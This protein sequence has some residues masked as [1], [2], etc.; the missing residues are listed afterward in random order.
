LHADRAIPWFQRAIEHETV[1]VLRAVATRNLAGAWLWSHRLDQAEETARTA[2]RLAE[3]AAGKNARETLVPELIIASVLFERG[4]YDRVEP[5]FRRLQFQA[6]HYWG[7]DSYEAGVIAGNLGLLYLNQQRYSQARPM[8]EKSAKVLLRH[9]GLAATFDIL[10]CR[11]LIA[12][13]LASENR[14]READA[15]LGPVLRDAEIALG[16]DSIELA[17]LLMRAGLAKL[18][19][20]QADEGRRMFE[21]AIGIFEAQNGVGSPEAVAASKRYLGALLEAK[22]SR[23]A[24]QVAARLKSAGRFIPLNYTPDPERIRPECASQRN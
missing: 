18:R 14:V 6:E 3:A 22:D 15:L 8:L 7:A 17:N 11:V 4:E 19:M 23:H 13:T 16:A 20:K 10:H 24:R 21:H 9:S 1:P 12:L 5:V 2:L